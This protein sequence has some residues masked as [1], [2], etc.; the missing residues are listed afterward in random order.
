MTL[1]VTAPALALPELPP[2][3]SGFSAAESGQTTIELTWT[4][5]DGV[6]KYRID[7][8][9][10]DPVEWST[11]TEDATDAEYTVEN[12]ACGTTYN[13]RLTAHGNGVTYQG[14]SESIALTIA[15][16]ASCN[17]APAFLATT[18]NFPIAEDATP[19]TIVG[20]APATDDDD[21]AITYS[22]L[23]EEEQPFTIDEST[24]EIQVQGPLDYETQN[25][26]SLVVQAT[27]SQSA[28]TTTTVTITVTD[29][30]EPPAFEKNSYDFSVPEDAAAGQD[31][32][33]ISATDQDANDTLIYAIIS[34]NDTGTFRLTTAESGVQLSVATPLDYEAESTYSLTV[35]ATDTT[36]R[37]TTSTLVITVTEVVEDTTESE[38]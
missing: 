18:H 6:D 1:P 29:V 37:S 7:Q 19:S 35:E 23:Q 8:T 16:T 14:W 32:G 17:T 12:L 28:A 31:I 9:L 27:D 34:G 38:K 15:T 25:E 21:D 26:Y 2:A 5:L 13:F 3:P 10:E 11:I 33:T 20:I 36:G 22:I 24:A 30:A 4:T